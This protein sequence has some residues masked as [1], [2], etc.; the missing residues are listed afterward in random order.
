MS[1]WRDV[2]SLRAWLEHDGDIAGEALPIR[3]ILA[4]LDRAPLDVRPVR[5][6]PCD[7]GHPRR[8]HTGHEDGDGECERDECEC[9]VYEARG[10]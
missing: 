9:G 8:E 2:A 7:C 1:E 10:W 4:R 3:S 6:E 5:L